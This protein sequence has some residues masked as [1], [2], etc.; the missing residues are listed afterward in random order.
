MGSYILVRRLFS[1]SLLL[2]V[3]AGLS[4]PAFADDNKITIMIGGIEK[5]IYLPAKLAEQLGYFKEQGI[6][7][8]LQSQPAG[9]EAEN[10]LLAGSVQGVVGFY[11]HTIDLQTKNKAVLSVVQFSQAPGEVVLVSSKQAAQIK[12][13]RDFKGKN[14]GVTGLGSST[15]F[16]MQYL[17]VT[18][19]VSV[20][21]ITAIPVGAGSTFIA[22]MTKG[23][24]DVGM[25]TEPTISR[26]LKTGDA[27]VLVDLRTPQTTINALGGLYPAA[28]LYM[29]TA[30]VNSHKPTVQKL[31]NALVK[32]LKY[33]HTHSA[34]EIA[35]HMPADYYAGDKAAYV[36]ALAA[37]KAM[38]TPDGKMPPSGPP[39]V[40]KVLSAFD[41]NVQGKSVD[42]SRTFTTEFVSAAE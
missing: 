8:E 42:L 30:W 17:S 19:G 2:F 39:T 4:I 29:P 24:I 18:N 21:E 27:K 36:S 5:Q 41:K 31:A 34:E 11:D 33:I 16:L 26:M 25:T 7:V 10:E 28:S 14:L 13:P 40:L 3:M 23:V 9:V 38:F 22:A 20:K 15:N 1:I 6:T 32:T 35:S 37:S 12:S